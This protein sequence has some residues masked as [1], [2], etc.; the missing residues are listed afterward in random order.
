MN[1]G[2]DT[3]VVLRLLTDEPQAQARRALRE[4]EILLRQECSLFVADMVV[5]EVYFALQHHYGV[6]K[7]EALSMILDLFKKSGLKASG[8]AA[9]VLTIP[10]PAAANP[11]FVDRLIHA[12]Y[13]ESTQEML[14]FEKAASRLSRVR[15]LHEPG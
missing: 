10:N 2:L 11:G 1:I 8:A 6:P 7:A 13:L 12:E 9:S 4:V 15:V 14:T 3:S 5:A